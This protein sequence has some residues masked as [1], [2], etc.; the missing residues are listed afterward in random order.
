MRLCEMVLEQRLDEL[1]M[2]PSNLKKMASSVDAIAGMEFEMIVPIQPPSDEL[3]EDWDMDERVHD[4]NDIIRFFDTGGD[5]SD[6]IIDKLRDSLDEDYSAWRASSAREWFDEHQDECLGKYYGEKY[7]YEGDE[8]T[9]AIADADD[10][11]KRL[12]FS[13]LMGDID[14]DPYEYEFDADTWATTRFD[15]MRDVYNRYDVYWP[16]MM[17]EDSGGDIGS[18]AEDFGQAIGKN[19]NH[20]ERYGGALRT[21]GVY[22]VEPDGSLEPDDDD[23]T[24]LEF[25]SPPMP[26]AQL[27]EDLRKVREWAG[28]YGCYTN[29]SCGLHINVSIPDTDFG[30]LD[31]VKLALFLGDQYVL[32]QFGRLG[33]TYCE[34]ALSKIEHN[35]D[36]LDNVG[37]V[38]D[39]VRRGLLLTAAKVIHSGETNKYVSINV[40]SGY[41]EFRSPGGDWLDSNFELIEST[42]YRFVVALDIAMDESKYKQEYSKRLYKMLANSDMGTDDVTRYFAQYSAGTMNR[43]QLTRAINQIRDNRQRVRAPN[44]RPA[45]T[46]SPVRFQVVDTNTG[47]VE[48][49]FGTQEAAEQFLELWDRSNPRSR[50]TLEV[51]PTLD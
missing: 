21:P 19:T 1:N 23:G 3:V 38:M 6:Q 44:R 33:N 11:D 9:A 15:T 2:S 7:G 51:R 49:T 8:L 24:G 43:A 5:N 20:S 26:I 13:N 34:S 48:T 41:V 45:T 10:R 37:S 50:G 42:L 18:V 27:L 32:E 31:Y 12:A 17:E 25:I 30:N 4:F 46:T 47:E 40:K 28:M 22:S 16:H 39:K 29:S 14:M 36:R 35:I